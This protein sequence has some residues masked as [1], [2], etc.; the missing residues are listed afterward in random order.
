MVSTEFLLLIDIEVELA[1]DTY[2]YQK[3]AGCDILLFGTA[4]TTIVG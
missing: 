1:Y 2:L 4:A 3:P